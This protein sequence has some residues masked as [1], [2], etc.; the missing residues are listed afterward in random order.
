M[1][2]NPRALTGTKLLLCDASSLLAVV[3]SLWFTL[4]GHHCSVSGQLMSP[5]TRFKPC[6]WG[7]GW[8]WTLE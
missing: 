3:Q 4:P 5:V 6:V 1:I 8:G 2:A 7:C